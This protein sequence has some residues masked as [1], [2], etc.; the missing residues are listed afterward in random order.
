MGTEEYYTNKMV[1]P[2]PSLANDISNEVSR[3][4]TSNLHLKDFPVASS[5]IRFVIP[6]YLGVYL[7]G[8]IT[9]EINALMINAYVI[10]LSE[11]PK[12]ND[13]QLDI[14]KPPLGVAFPV[15]Q[16][17]RYTMTSVGDSDALGPCVL[18]ESS[19]DKP[20][21]FRDLLESLFLAVIKKSLACRLH[22]KDDPLC[23]GRGSGEVIKIFMAYA[24]LRKPFNATYDH[25]RVELDNIKKRKREQDQ[26]EKVKR[27][28][29]AVLDIT[30]ADAKKEIEQLTLEAPFGQD[31]LSSQEFINISKSL[32]KHVAEIKNKKSQC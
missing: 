11:N 12:A 3:I 28:W 14:S 23:S 9:S 25:E 5:S 18:D 4:L 17:L 32:G 29:H 20:K 13:L 7:N 19:T 8:F 6:I 30:Y 2:D 22:E 31:L 10:K 15:K 24:A 26:L 27:E 1:I 16:I 21:C